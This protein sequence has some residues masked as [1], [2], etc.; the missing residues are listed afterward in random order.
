[1]LHGC[2]DKVKQMLQMLQD[3]NVKAERLI[4]NYSDKIRVSYGN[5]LQRAYEAQL[6]TNNSISN[7]IRVL[8]AKSS[9][10]T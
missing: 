5:V 7:L 9:T 3:H 2:N 6:K 1:M 8:V 10:N 4:S